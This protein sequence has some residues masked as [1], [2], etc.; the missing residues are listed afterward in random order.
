M[1]QYDQFR[2][3]GMNHAAIGLEQSDT[4]VTYY[5]TPQDAKIIGWAGVDGI[6][7][8]TIPKFGDVIFA[9]SPMNL[10]DCVHPIA[11]TF[12]DLLRLLLT[13]GDMAVLEQCYAWNREQFD[14]FLLDCPVT[15]KQKKILDRVKKKFA[16]EPMEDA[17]GYVKR[18]Q[19]EF[20]LSQIPYTE[21]YYDPDMNAAAPEPK[22]WTVTY[23]GNFWGN[24]GEPGREI[25]VRKHFCWGNEAWYI[26]AVYACDQGLVVDYLLEVEPAEMNAF[27]CKWDLI[28]QNE[29]AYSEEQLE[30]IEWENPLNVEFDGKLTVN[31]IVLRST[32]GCG[33]GWIPESCRM[34][35]MEPQRE[36]SYVLNHYG[37]N[38]ESAWRISRQCYAWGDLNSVEPESLFLRMER[39]PVNFYGNPFRTPEEG[40]SVSVIHPVT[41][42]KFTLTVHAVERKELPEHAF[43]DPAMEYP[44]HFVAMSYSMEPDIRQRGF[45]LRDC[46]RGDDPRMKKSDP[47]ELGPVM[48]SATA[49]GVIGGSDGPT[50][51]IVGQ[52]NTPRRYAACSALRFEPVETVDWLP[53][54]SEKTVDDLEIQLI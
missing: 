10:G 8:C 13:C 3:M 21:D 31:G 14:A 1:V 25:P 46:A 2:K 33:M 11:R 26:P 53:V 40:E 28:N 52:T 24:R 41:G 16:L 39:H 19:S 54:F 45:M 35:G 36:M 12:E 6:H 47:N 44:S 38:R 27:F 4:A 5:C 42:Q 34:E 17:F 7:Y 18:L 43:R 49:I 22:E 50:A 9:V 30:R 48:V 29:R 15:E 20:D 51:M 23:N 37:L 32:H